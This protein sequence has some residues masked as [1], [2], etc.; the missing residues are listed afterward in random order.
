VRRALALASAGLLLAG[1][2]SQAAQQETPKP[3][4]L[5]RA[6][7][8]SWARQAN[9]VATAL[10]AG[11]GCTALDHANALRSGVDGA[12]GDIPRRLRAMLQPMVDA[13][14]GRITCNPP[15]PSPQPHPPKDHHDHG[16][17]KGHG[18]DEG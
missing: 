6:L 18:G 15:P 8:S 4:R 16:K 7:A 12:A 11:D 9:A 13:L 1:C 10:A 5:P 17:H 3:P 2:G 14:P